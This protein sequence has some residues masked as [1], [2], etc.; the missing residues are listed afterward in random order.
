MC[1]LRKVFG[2]HLTDLGVSLIVAHES[3][4]HPLHLLFADI[5]SEYSEVGRNGRTSASRTTVQNP[6]TPLRGKNY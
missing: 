4:P 2:C 5:M 3:G 6:K 1:T